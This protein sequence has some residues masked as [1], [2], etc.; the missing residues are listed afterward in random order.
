MQT[1]SLH[2]KAL[3]I[4][5][6]IILSQ[7]LKMA[8]TKPKHVTMLSLNVYIS[9]LCYTKILLLLTSEKYAPGMLQLKMI[10]IQPLDNQRCKSCSSSRRFRPPSP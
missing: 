5:C 10:T 6:L 3:L 7:T 8:S 1:K 2:F 9:K 4:T